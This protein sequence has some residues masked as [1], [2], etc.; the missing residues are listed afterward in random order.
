LLRLSKHH[1]GKLTD[2]L[3]VVRERLIGEIMDGFE[4]NSFPPRVLPLADQ[5][6]FALGYYHQRQAFFTKSESKNQE[7]SQ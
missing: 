2:G 6:R 1:L 4:A 7:E 3:A 5:A